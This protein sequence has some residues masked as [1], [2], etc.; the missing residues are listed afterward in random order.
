MI[1]LFPFTFDVLALH[2][3]LP[4]LIL[5]TTIEHRSTVSLPSSPSRLTSR[6]LRPFS[7]IFLLSDTVV[8]CSRCRTACRHHLRVRLFTISLLACLCVVSLSGIVSALHINIPASGLIR[9]RRLQPISFPV[10]VLSR[11][12]VPHSLSIDRGN[13]GPLLLSNPLHCAFLDHLKHDLGFI[14]YL[15]PSILIRTH[16]WTLRLRYQRDGR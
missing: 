15:S 6:T 1:F 13:Y 8:H 12:A 9:V 5:D 7:K 4:S 14:S 2:V 11:V 16:M 10:C 3:T